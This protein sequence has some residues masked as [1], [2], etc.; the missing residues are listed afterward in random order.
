MWITILGRISRFL[1]FKHNES[2]A[3]SKDQFQRYQIW[4]YKEDKKCK[5]DFIACVCGCAEMVLV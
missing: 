2:L 4:Q 1:L 5:A 3:L